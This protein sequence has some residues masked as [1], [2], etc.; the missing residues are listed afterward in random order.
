MRKLIG[1][2]LM[3]S[4]FSVHAAD[5]GYVSLFV[6]GITFFIDRTTPPEITVNVVGV[7]DTQ[8]AAIKDGLNLSVKQAIGVLVLSDQT[9]NNDKVVR[10]LVA[11]YSAG[12]VNS[13]KVKNCA[14]I[15]VSCEMTAKVSPWKF[16]RKLE[17]DSS[18]IRVN[19]NDMFAKHQ[20]A[21][22]VLLQRHKITEYYLS[23]IR[24]SGLDVSILSVDV[25]PTRND[26]VKLV[27]DYEVKWN[28]DYKTE[29]IGF[30]EKLEEETS[31]NKDWQ[32]IY[33]QW[34]TTGFRENRVRIFSNDKQY[35]KL[36]DKY[37]YEP[38][39]VYFKE[40]GVCV[41]IGS[42]NIFTLDWYGGK[43]QTTVEIEPEKL[44]DV[45]S[46]TGRIGCGKL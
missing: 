1:C 9:V 34:N 37:V 42:K 20:T 18:T 28:R 32:Q 26:K 12:V 27:L 6:R 39:F 35:V 24:Q 10:N 19:G 40:I 23:Q 17:G 8:D 29:L 16:M 4:A 44:K 41:D 45:R 14:G 15:P 31:R 33:I 43:R 3:A 2:L 11:E 46:I 22:N 21:K 38:T 25:L 36:F 7:G 13:F 5:F 30:L